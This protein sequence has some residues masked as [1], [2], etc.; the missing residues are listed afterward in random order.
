MNEAR[1][2]HRLHQMRVALDRIEAQKRAV[3]AE[4]FDRQLALYDDQHPFRAAHPGRRSGKSEY[5]PRGSILDVL[6]A[7]FNEVVLVGAETKDKAKSLHWANL[8]AVVARH[9]L[10]LTPNGQRGAWVTPWGSAVQFWGMRDKNAVE[11]LRG[12]KLK[13]ARF[14]EVATYAAMLPRL[15]THVVEP[16]LADTGGKLDLL[17][18]PSVTRSG[19][20]ADICLGKTPGWSVHHWTLLENPKFPR[21]PIKTLAEARE[22]NGWTEDSA[23]YRREYMGEF[24]NDD[25]AQVYRYLPERN[26][27]AA[28]PANYSREKWLHVVAVDFGVV[29]DCA[30]TVIAAHPQVPVAYVIQS[31]KRDRLLVS[32]AAEITAQLCTEYKPIAL[33]G[34]VG[35]LGKPYAEEWNRR[36]SGKHEMPSMVPAEKTEKRGAIDNLNTDLRTSALLILA[37]E[38]AELTAELEGLPWAPGRLKE[39]PAYPNHCTDALLYAH[40]ALR[41]YRFQAPEKS[42]ADRDPDDAAKWIETQEAEQMRQEMQAEDWERY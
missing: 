23:T 27:V 33:V 12:F 34:D 42:L 21:D 14:D 20:W 6:D 9:K 39:D 37:E 38:C 15:T 41:P 19:P 3:R 8:A 30:W 28:L 16:A 35:G 25:E 18:T 11:L 13:A 2:L 5:V 22:R 7:G 4:C 26:N 32:E 31:F 40:R 24:V 1:A 10:P 29:D 36:Y 17:G